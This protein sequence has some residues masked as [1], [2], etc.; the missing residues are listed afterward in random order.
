MSF[1]TSDRDRRPR[2]GKRPAAGENRYRVILYPGSVFGTRSATN[3]LLGVD[4]EAGIRV[5]IALAGGACVA[6]AMMAAD[7]A[8]EPGGVPSAPTITF[9]YDQVDTL[10]PTVAWIGQAHTGYEVHIGTVNTPTS[11]DGWDSGEVTTATRGT[12]SGLLLPGRAYYVHVRLRNASGWGTWSAGAAFATPAAPWVKILCPLHADSVLGPSISVQWHTIASEP[13]ASVT[14]TVDDGAPIVLPGNAT[15]VDLPDLAAGVRLVR[16]VI[17]QDGGA[18]AEGSIRFYVRQPIQADPGVLYVMDLRYLKN[19]NRADPAQAR[20]VYDTCHFVSTLQGIV[21]KQGPRLYVRL[22]DADDFWLDYLTAPGGWLEHRTRVDIASIDE[23]VA[24]FRADFEGVVVYDPD[25]WATS[26]IAS[27][28]AG[29]ES[30]PAIRYDPTPGSIYQQLV[31]KQP[32]LPVAGS[33]VGMFTGQGTIPDSTTP[34]TGSKKCD[35]YIWAK[36]QYLDT[37]RCEPTELGYYL[38]S[39]WLTNPTNGALTEHCLMNHDYLVRV[40]GFIWD[41]SPWDDEAPQDDPTQPLGTDCNTLKSILLSAYNASGGDDMIH[42]AG[43]V[44]WAF[45][46]TAHPGGSQH[47]PV[48]TEWQYARIASAYNAYM[49]ADA[50]GISG[51]ANASLF[52]Q[53]PLPD[54]LLQNP[55]PSPRDLREMG[56]LS[57]TGGVAP[58]TFLMFYIG[59][60]DSAAWVYSQLVP[61]KWASPDRGLVPMGWAIN[62]NLMMRMAPAFDYCYRMKTDQDTFIAGDSGAGY[63]NPTQLLP[64]RWPSSL[65]GAGE[66]WQRHCLPFY[67]RFNYGIT[68]FL[69]NGYSGQLNAETELLYRSF[70]GD[71]IMTQ[72]LWMN[73]SNHLQ[74]GMPV[75]EMRRDLPNDQGDAAAVIH[76]DARAEQMQLLSYRTILKTPTYLRQIFERLTAEHPEFAYEMVSP[77]VYFDLLRHTLGS[78]KDHRTTYTF[79]TIPRCM[80]RGAS[81]PVAV[82]VRNEGWRAWQVGQVSLAIGIS[83]ESQRADR[84]MVS[85]PRDLEP[86][87]AEVLEFTI[88]A[89]AEAGVYLLQYDMVDG[90]TWFEDAADIPWEAQI[91]VV[92][93]PTLDTD[94]DGLPDW[95]EQQY[96]DSATDAAPDEDPDED[97]QTNLE[98]FQAGT[99]PAE[100]EVS[101]P[102]GLVAPGWNLISLPLPPSD[103]APASVFPGLPLDGNLARYDCRQRTYIIYRDAAPGDFGD[104]EAGRGYWLRCAAPATVGYRGH[105]ISGE[106]QVPLVCE[107]EWALIGVPVAGDRALAACGMRE[108]TSGDSRTLPEAV[109]AGWADFPLYWFD[110]VSGSYRTATPDP[111]SSDGSLRAWRG[112]WLSI[113]RADLALT[114]WP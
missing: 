26:N 41:L 13:V 93:D 67:R 78:D 108:L 21:N 15:E 101:S 36:E 34:S 104:L 58:L 24:T 19:Y 32:K 71:G 17:T 2:A 37:G 94:G 14:V 79:D 64:P 25:V 85:L 75:A 59:D 55:Q 68:G 91:E 56:Y 30:V 39:Y 99:D 63:V 50:A 5:L 1:P 83:P 61:V 97:G 96:F 31:V 29:V 66:A 70:S 98:E 38:D 10:T 43:F 89:P 6:A 35:A 65:P 4:M 92:E 53:M 8:P 80:Y 54:R 73:G 16:V 106:Q 27:T 18:T 46:Y 51:M 22:L 77:Q 103:P 109:A 52:C 105:H 69:I 113:H 72:P 110:A 23:L 20:L 76:G 28:I 7:A 82:G 57:P 86:G 88:E 114:V 48:P 42:V 62:P 49:D 100:V 9:P 102:P 3:A 90:A 112:H 11:N 33:L 47:E 74:N 84:M 44:P 60:Y 45:K 95:W 40:G 107:S 81:Y 12:T 111:W 87:D